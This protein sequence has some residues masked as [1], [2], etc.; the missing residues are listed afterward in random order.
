ME[1]KQQPVISM[2]ATTKI[3]KYMC[4]L[5]PEEIEKMVKSQLTYNLSKEI[6]EALERGRVPYKVTLEVDPLL[7][8]WDNHTIRINLI[9]D[10]ELDRLRN[11]EN[12]YYG[13]TDGRIYVQPLDMQD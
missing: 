1:E 4:R 9:S 11:I 5:P 8:A 13:N 6:M 3:D 2:Y 10:K 7:G 12:M